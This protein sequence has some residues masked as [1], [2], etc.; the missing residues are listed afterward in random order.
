MPK[1]AI[2]EG[3]YEL[4]KDLKLLLTSIEPIFMS[5]NP[6]VVVAAAKA[7]YYL[8]PSTDGHWKKFVGPLLRL[9]A[10][11]KEVE[12]VV[13]RYLVVLSSRQRTIAVCRFD[14]DFGIL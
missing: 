14:F 12:R 8:A 3:E 7:C 4:D 2:A 1:P 13:V 10:I 11:S 5:R 9:L 6:A